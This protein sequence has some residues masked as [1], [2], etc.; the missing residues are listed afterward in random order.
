MTGVFDPLITD[1]DDLEDGQEIIL[2]PKSNNPLTSKAHKFVFSGGY[3]YS[4]PPM[5][6]DIG[7]DYYLGDVSKY[8]EGWKPIS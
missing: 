8:N 2:Q 7:P 4:D 1:F 6:S 3:F 5:S